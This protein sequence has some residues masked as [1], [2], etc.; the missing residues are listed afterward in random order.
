ME[1][2]SGF[3]SPIQID[4]FCRMKMFLGDFQQVINTRVVFDK[5]AIALKIHV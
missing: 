2:F 3:G 1:V 5:L 4:I